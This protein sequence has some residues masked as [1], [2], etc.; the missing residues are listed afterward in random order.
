MLQNLSQENETFITAAVASG[1]YHD[2]EAAIEAGVSMLRKHEELISRLRE[3]RRQLD[4]GDY[5]EFDDN[6]L[7]EFAERLKERARHAAEA[8]P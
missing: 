8:N 3:S 4:E 6:G 2:R 7:M 1:L 5:V